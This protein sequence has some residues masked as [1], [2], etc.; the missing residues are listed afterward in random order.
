MDIMDKVLQNFK[1]IDCPAGDRCSKPGCQWKHSRDS[2]P[3]PKSVGLDGAHEDE[4]GPRK[5]RKLSDELVQT[6]KK[7]EVATISK[8]VSPPPLKR[9]LPPATPSNASNASNASPKKQT[10]LRDS[11]LSHTTT[12]NT[13]PS[14]PVTAKK[15]A[16]TPRKPE[17][18]NPRHLRTKAPAAHDFRCK[19]T[20]MLHDQFVRLNKEMQKDKSDKSLVLSDQELIWLTLDME[21]KTAID[22]PSIY[23]NIIKNEITKYKKMTPAQ[24]KDERIAAQKKK[25]KAAPENMTPKAKKQALMGP[26]TVIATGLT[27]KEEIAF[28][29][30]LYTPITELSRYGYVVSPPTE[31]EIAKARQGVEAGKGYEECDRCKQRFQVFPGRRE[32]DG[33]LASGGKCTYHWGKLYTPQS[34]VAGRVVERGLRSYRCCK[35][36]VGESSGCVQGPHHVFKVNHPARLASV[37]PFVETPVN[38]NVPRDRAVAFDC[39]MC[40]TVQGMELLR[41]TATSWPDGAELLDVLVRPVGEVLDLNSRF[42]G[43]WPKDIQDAVLWSP[44]DGWDGKLPSNKEDSQPAGQEGSEHKHKKK[45]YIVPSPVV[46]RDLLFSIISRETPLIGHGLEN[47]LNAVRVVHPTLVDT[48]LLFPHQKGL[49]I[50]N[51]LRLLME[52]ELNTAIQVEDDS[53]VDGKGEI[54]D[55][56]GHDSAEDA[57]AAGELVRLRIMHKWK[58]MQINGWTLKDGAFVPPPGWQPP[59]GASTATNKGVAARANAKGLLSEGFLEKGPAEKGAAT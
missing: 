19:A 59:R 10:T 28:L 32:E 22:K 55:P 49:P 29:P 30:H 24:W 21:E 43:V 38:P 3:T 53:A 31:E 46:A 13:K 18:L 11:S 40:Y 35:Q 33:A 6:N 47:D 41:I 54:L 2:E 25:N 52:R 26:P 15:D 1:K 39:E 12:P 37:I 42:S 50:R 9:K 51:G 7:P 23:S 44:P 8:P 58:M 5:R 20:K 56:Q 34:T 57:R 17:S 4:D 27:P 16:P 36:A 14:T 48:V 45:M